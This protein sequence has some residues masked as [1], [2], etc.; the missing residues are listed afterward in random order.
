MLKGESPCC[1]SNIYIIR[2]WGLFFFFSC[3][4]FSE[5]LDIL[6]ITLVVVILY[7]LVYKGL[8]VNYKGLILKVFSVHSPLSH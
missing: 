6:L 5:C 8:T 1:S 2:V 3:L 4:E 7:G